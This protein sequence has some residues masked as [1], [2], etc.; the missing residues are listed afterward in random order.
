VRACS[1]NRHDLWI[2]Q[3]DSAMVDE[4]ALP[5][6]SGLDVA[7]VVR[8][9]GPGA[10]AVEGDRVLLCPNRTCGSC[11]SCR[12]GPGNLCQSFVLYH[13]GWP[14]RRPWTPTG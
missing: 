2:L 14:S 4:G 6:V 9:V 5:F 7:G 8:E 11:E 10:S 1:V 3:G 12:E 13:G